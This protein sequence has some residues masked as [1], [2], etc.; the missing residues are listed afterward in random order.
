MVVQ[1]LGSTTLKSESLFDPDIAL[2]DGTTER[3][4]FTV[5]RTFNMRPLNKFLSVQSNNADFR[6]DVVQ[7][8]SKNYLFYITETLNL[9]IQLPTYIFAWR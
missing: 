5:V 9:Y 8:M 1:V 7:Q 4:F 6:Y 2:R 3:L